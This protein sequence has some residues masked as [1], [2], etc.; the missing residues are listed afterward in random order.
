MEQNNPDGGERID[1]G[2]SGPRIRVTEEHLKLRGERS[3]HPIERAIQDY[4]DDDWLHCYI[5]GFDN[6]VSV[7]D[8]GG[9]HVW[10]LPPHVS[11]TFN[12]IILLNKMVDQGD[13][14]WAEK[15]WANILPFD[16]FL[17]EVNYE[18]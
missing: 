8:R 15:F 3:G 17:E 16:F 2:P 14:A 12:L 10:N 18:G 4:F 7:E 13:S 6:L 11:T 9:N 1:D 5:E